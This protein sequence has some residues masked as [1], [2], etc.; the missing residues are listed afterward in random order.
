MEKKYLEKVE[1]VDT[2]SQAFMVAKSKY[3]KIKKKENSQDIA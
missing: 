3:N 1:E 2:V